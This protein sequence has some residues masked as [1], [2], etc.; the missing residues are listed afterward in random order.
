MLEKAKEEVT[1]M[2][3]GGKKNLENEKIK[4]VAQATEEISS[5]SVKIAEKILGNKI[6]ESFDEKTMKELNK[7]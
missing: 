5:L 1:V 3:E 4:M 6:D 2:I 7:I